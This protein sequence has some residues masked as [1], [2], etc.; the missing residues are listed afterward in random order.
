MRILGS[1]VRRSRGLL[2][3]LAAGCSSTA[4]TSS[5]DAATHAEAAS[6]D[7]SDARGPAADDATAIDAAIDAAD[8]ASSDAGAGDAATGSD[9]PGVV[10]AGAGACA[11]SGAP[12]ICETTTACAAL[13]GHTSFPGQCPGPASVECCIVTPSTADNPSVPAGWV[14][15]QQAQ[16]TSAMTAWAVSIL[17]DPATYPMF[18]TAMQTFGTQ[19]VL[20]RVE[21]HPPDFQN[22]VVHRG[23]TLYVPG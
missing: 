17:D 14:L 10:D 2:V 16:V 6:G 18:A 3:L 5:L 8:A 20:A 15:M 22:S 21:W 13:G 9:A 12:G 23:V 11:V 1:V 4:S 7:A 19:P